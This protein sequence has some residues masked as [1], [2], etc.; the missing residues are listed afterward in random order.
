[1]KPIAM[2]SA[3]LKSKSI[4]KKVKVDLVKR[5][6]EDSPDVVIEE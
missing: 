2:L 5:L 6:K 1:M 3:L 4:E